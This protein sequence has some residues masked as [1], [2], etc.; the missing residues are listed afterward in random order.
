MSDLRYKSLN[1]GWYYSFLTIEN[2]DS[3]TKEL[4][5]LRDSD[6]K[7]YYINKHYINILATDIGDR[8]PILT[9]FLK[10]AGLDR[11]FQRL[12]YSAYYGGAEVAHVDSYDPRYCSV[13]LNLPL[14]DCENSYTVWYKTN[15]KKLRDITTT[16]RDPTKVGHTIGQHF[17]YLPLDE[18]TEIC[19]A[20]VVRPMLVNTTI[21]HRGVVPSPNRTICGI[22][23]NSELTNEEVLNL[24]IQQPYKQVD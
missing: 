6:V 9:N 19:R 10:S 3:L 12:L 11:K 16:G 20:E 5:E 14:S 17:A 4:I 8:A 24:G 21:L 2:L 22:R 15:K 1:K 13:S 23:F 18:T 7:R